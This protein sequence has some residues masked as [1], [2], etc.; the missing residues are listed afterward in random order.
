MRRKLSSFS[1][2]L[3]AANRLTPC[4]LSLRDSADLVKEFER[5]G[6]DWGGIKIMRAKGFL[7]A[8]KIV[9]LPVFLANILKQ[10]MLSLGG[11]VAISRGSI[12]GQD[13]VTDCI[14]LGTLFQ[15][16][17]LEQ[18]LKKQPF[19]FS[20]ISEK[21]AGALKNVER[22][23]LSLDFRGKRFV[24]G[25]KTFV[26][27]IINVT[28]DSFSGDGLLKGGS[29]SALAQAVNMIESGADMLDIGG[30]SS[31]PGSRR[32]SVKAEIKR[33]LPALKSLKSKV[34]APIS[35]DTMKSEVAHAALQEGASIINDI[36]AGRFDKKILKVVARHKAGI[37]LM[38]MKGTPSTMQKN[39]H[40]D[41]VMEDIFSFLAE[42]V[43]R[44]QDA[45][46][47][48]RR[49]IVDPGI[50]FGKDLGHNLEILRRLAEFKSLGKP[51]LIGVSKKRFIGQIL[52]KGVDERQWGTMAAISQ[53]IAGYVDIVRVHDV[54]E[55]KQV[56]AVSDR[57]VR[58]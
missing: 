27:G 16:S 23:Q 11:D 13:K 41:D 9:G 37:V 29:A 31:R 47:E 50:G 14:I 33:V 24:L 38:H 43:Q 32:I 53:A 34:K 58:N 15:F 19:G 8:V 26:M 52:K 28:P 54:K 10:E 30:E 7:R 22:K 40:Y 56:A 1:A 46:I 4:V 18:K 45:G 20:R 48:D 5:I 17:A 2:F 6:V 49:I 21:V 35:V 51:V 39:P 36:S 55:A 25:K 57:I 44:A 12:T 3:D 42:S